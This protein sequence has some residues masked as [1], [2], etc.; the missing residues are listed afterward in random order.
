MSDYTDPPAEG[1][2]PR[3]AMGTRRAPGCARQRLSGTQ[4]VGLAPRPAAHLLPLSS[5]A[6]LTTRRRHQLSAPWSGICG[7]RRA[8]P[9]GKRQHEL[10]VELT[11]QDGG[12]LG[13]LLLS[14][15]GHG[16]SDPGS[17]PHGRPAGYRPMQAADEH[18]R[19]GDCCSGCRRP[20]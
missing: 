14:C 1:V 5:V 19:L 12:V 9:E 15:C 16:G 2:R 17:E 11:A 3:S 20:I 8:V 10:T 6:A 7:A 18:S 13:R 4:L